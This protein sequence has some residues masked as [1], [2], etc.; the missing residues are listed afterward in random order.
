MGFKNNIKQNIVMRST[1]I[2]FFTILLFFG[3]KPDDKPPFEGDLLLT[4]EGELLYPIF[5]KGV[6]LSDK[7][8]ET[9]VCE[10]LEIDA[11]IELRN[12]IPLVETYFDLTVAT[13]YNENVDLVKLTTYPNIQSDT[14]KLKYDSNPN[15]SG[16]K[17]EVTFLADDLVDEIEY[18]IISGFGQVITSL[19]DLKDNGLYKRNFS[20]SEGYLFLRFKLYDEDQYRY[21]EFDNLGDNDTIQLDLANYPLGFFEDIQ[22]SQGDSIEVLQLTGLNNN[23]NF[24]NSIGIISQNVTIN[25]YRFPNGKAWYPQDVF[26][27]FYIQFQMNRD[28]FYFYKESKGAAIYEYDPVL[29]DLEIEGSGINSFKAKSNNSDADFLSVT[30]E[31]DKPEGKIEWKVYQKKNETS[32]LKLPELPTCIVPDQT[33]FSR[34]DFKVKSI[35]SYHYENYNSYD[36]YI[37]SRYGNEAGGEGE[38]LIL[39]GGDFEKKSLFK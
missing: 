34:E 39:I 29:P 1:T 7:N 12:N 10:K 37:E 6:F 32:F 19:S 25:N 33:W 31:V 11:S 17:G 5:G 28:S 38:A 20:I 23:L 3:C 4:L 16:D 15:T 2:L 22:S 26:D 30:W 21:V 35:D 8:G 13:S 9:L 36:E 18:G 27:S 24:N 14:W